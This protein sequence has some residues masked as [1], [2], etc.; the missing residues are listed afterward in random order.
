[1]QM[2]THLYKLLTLQLRLNVLEVMILITLKNV[3]I[4]VKCK[5]KRNSAAKI[6]LQ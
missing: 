6:N 3:S 4:Y 5:L 2:V 1:M